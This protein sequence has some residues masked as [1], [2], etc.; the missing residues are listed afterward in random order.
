MTIG[1]MMHWSLVASSEPFECRPETGASAERRSRVRGASCVRSARLSTLLIC[2]ET[3]ILLWKHMWDPP[4]I[5]QKLLAGSKKGIRDSPARSGKAPRAFHDERRGVISG[6][7]KP[8]KELSWFLPPPETPGSGSM[9]LGSA[10]S[11]RL[12]RLT[13]GLAVTPSSQ[14]STRLTARLTWDWVY[15][16]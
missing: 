9:R 2:A 4:A 11:V 15:G 13:G 10:A 7:F 12:T 5:G 3:Q 6:T 1:L 14:S 16:L 8:G